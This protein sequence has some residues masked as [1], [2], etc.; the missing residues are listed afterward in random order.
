MASSKKIQ[1]TMIFEIIG[2]PP[3]NLVTTLEG[4][5]KQID[6]EKGVT[7]NAKSIKEPVLMKG[8][9]DIYTTFAEVEL[10]AEE[11]MILA[12]LMFKYMPAH[13][14]VVSPESINISNHDFGDLLSE[15]TR[16]L[17]SYDE[18]ARVLEIKNAELQN[19]VIELTSKKKIEKTKKEEN[20]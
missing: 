3:E 8:Q 5:I 17:H 9:K 10:E 6:N 12:I 13:V 20:K 1:A 2:R 11:T 15:L 19:K 4:I 16:R 14:E 18:V 7:V